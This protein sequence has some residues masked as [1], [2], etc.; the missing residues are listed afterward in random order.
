[1]DDVAP[2]QLR[3]QVDTTRCLMMH[4]WPH[5]M[6]STVTGEDL[7]STDWGVA[8]TKHLSKAMRMVGCQ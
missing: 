8:Q 6:V 5:E 3:W 7:G 2:I 4:G 1:M